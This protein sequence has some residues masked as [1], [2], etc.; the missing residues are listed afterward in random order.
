MPGSKKTMRPSE[1]R[2]TDSRAKTLGSQSLLGFLFGISH[3]LLLETLGALSWLGDRFAVVSVGYLAVTAWIQTS[4]LRGFNTF[5]SCSLTFLLA[6][7]AFTPL[8]PSQVGSCIRV[9]QIG[10]IDAVV[11]LSSGNTD[12]SHLGNRALARLV[13]GLCTAQDL[14]LILTKDGIGAAAEADTLEITSKLNPGR[15]VYQVGP[16]YNTHDEAVEVAKLCNQRGYKS[17]ELITSPMH[18][19]RAAETFEA[20]GLTVISRPCVEREFALWLD[21]SGRITSKTLQ[22]PTDRIF[23]F[24]ALIYEFSGTIKYRRNGWMRPHP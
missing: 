3:L 2:A 6:V 15:R 18:S 4:K 5:G 19:K 11:T 9:D 17:I 14:P 16:V 7:I 1:P 12:D 22:S 21:Q 23:A 13:S 8:V 20:T 10:K 24:R